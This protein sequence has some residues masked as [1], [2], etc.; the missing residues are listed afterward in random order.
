MTSLFGQV[1][2]DFVI[3]TAAF[4]LIR[5]QS[6]YM[7]LYLYPNTS[8]YRTY[9]STSVFIV[10][11]YQY[12]TLAI[13]FSKGAPYR[14]SFLTNYAFVLNILMCFALSLYLTTYPANWIV[15]LLQ[16]VRIPS[17]WFI[18]ILHSMVL[19][20]FMAS[21][22][23]E[24]I[25]DGVSFRRRI[26]RIG[27]ALF[28]RR[29]ERKAYERIREEIDRSAGVWPPLLRSASLQALPRDLF[30]DE[31]L[32]VTT[33]PR[34]RRLSSAVSNDTDVDVASVQSEITDRRQL[35]FSSTDG[36]IGLH[37]VVSKLFSNQMSVNENPNQTFT[38]GGSLKK[39]NLSVV[40]NLFG[41]YFITIVIFTIHGMQPGVDTII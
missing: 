13:A 38:L 32:D 23:V 20:N 40:R 19:A 14:K 37:K 35:P 29:V 5:L 30:T 27:R 21:Y 16:L 12:I 3:Q 11:T 7:P 1:I 31:N 9:E 36:D 26:R 6:W 28:P 10:S 17:I 2:I 39:R 41:N 18:L 22:I 24:S 15:E 8:E 25:V 34:S 4:I 33:R